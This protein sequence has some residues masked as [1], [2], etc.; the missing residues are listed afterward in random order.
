MS[1][2][3]QSKKM[4]RMALNPQ[5]VL[6]K[7]RNLFILS[8]MRSRSSVLSHVLGSNPEICG[9]RELQFSYLSKLSL[10]KMRAELSYDLQS[11]LKDKY[12]LDKVLHNYLKI[13]QNILDSEDTKVLF[14]LREP[15]STI[16][17][18]TN[19][20]TLTGRT[21]YKDPEVAV[22]YYCDRL[23]GLKDFAKRLRHKYFFIE[24]NDLIDKTDSVLASMSQW[25]ALETPLNKEYSKF[26]KTGQHRHGDPSQNINAGVIKST[27]GYPD[28]VIDSSLLSKAEE[29]YRICIDSLQEGQLAV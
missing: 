17:S 4:V 16:Q 26:D 7:T 22:S 8:H 15:K 11:S 3:L 21:T 12:L 14:L 18:I 10:I 27:K 28:T 2:F 1:L 23:S 5:D 24:S 6:C 29:A 9:Y 20:A 13:S 25:L 19:L